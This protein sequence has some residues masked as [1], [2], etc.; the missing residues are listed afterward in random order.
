MIIYAAGVFDLIHYGHINYLREAKKYGDVLIVGLLTDEGAKEY[1]FV[2]PI[3]NYQE[4]YKLLMGIK[5]VNHIVPQEHTDPTSTLER[6]W[7]CHPDMFPKIL[8]RADDVASP[9]PG[10]EFMKSKGSRVAIVSYT[11]GISD[12]DIKNR[13]IDSW[14]VK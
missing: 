11:S 4:R 3:M 6:M 13:I 7:N 8:V 1:K 9:V 12:T 2:Y 14:G 5:Y 10:E